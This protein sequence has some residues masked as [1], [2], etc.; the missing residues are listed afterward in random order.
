MSIIVNKLFYLIIVLFSIS[1]ITFG[2]IHLA[3]GDPAEIILRSFDSYTTEE[4]VESLR[5]RIGTNDPVYIQ[6]INWFYRIVQLDFGVSYQTGE[7]VLVEIL[8][9]V[10]ATLELA[11]TSFI[12]T[13]LISFFLGIFSA[14]KKDSFFD[15]ISRIGAIISISTPGFWLGLLLLYIFS[16]RYRIFPIMGRG[17]LINLVLPSVTLSLGLAGLYGRVFRSSI[18]DVLSQDYI[19]Y[20]YAKGLSQSVVVLRHVLRNSVLPCI[21]LLGI[22][23]GNLLGGSAIVESIFAWPGVGKLALDAIFNRDYPIIMGYVLF[24]SIIFVLTNTIVDISYQLLDPRIRKGV[25]LKN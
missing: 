22:C 24:M 4:A 18:V 19:K 11:V 2:L 6:Y 3:P 14:I 20:A 17:G 23:F 15:H 7:S 21:T 10:P 12:L 16:V 13:F 1:I 8:S 25:R 9:R 5:D